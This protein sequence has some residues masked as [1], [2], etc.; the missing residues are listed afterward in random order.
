[1]D[2]RRGWARCDERRR[3]LLECLML[4]QLLLLQNRHHSFLNNSSSHR[5]RHKCPLSL[6][7]GRMTRKREIHCIVEDA[8]PVPPQPLFHLRRR[9]NSSLRS[10]FLRH[11]DSSQRQ[12]QLQQL[13][14]STNKG[15]ASHTPLRRAPRFL[16][17]LQR[18]SRQVRT[19][20]RP[21]IAVLPSRLH[22]TPDLALGAATRKRPDS[23]VLA[24]IRARWDHQRSAFGA[25]LAR[26]RTCV[27]RTAPRH[28]TRR[29]ATRILQVLFT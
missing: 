5:R 12:L 24:R 27:L 11:Q 3:L 9:H 2:V 10:L 8:D 20:S 1:M 29:M 26:S 4:Q 14:R 19:S 28:C 22:R 17:Q 18:S 15:L 21:W 25:R 13:G 23:I 6:I 16:R 7:L